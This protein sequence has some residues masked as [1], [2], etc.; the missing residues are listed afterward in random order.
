MKRLFFISGLLFLILSCTTGGSPV[1][2]KSDKKQESVIKTDT[3]ARS[4]IKD[5]VFYIHRNSD[6]FR[7]KILVPEKIRGNLLILHGWNLPADELCSKT[8]LCKMALDSG[9]VLIIPDFGKTT[10]QWQNYPETLKKYLKY[11]TRH[12]M[13]DTFLM[14]MQKL[15][16]LNGNERNFVYGVSTGGRGA[17][18][19]ALENP[20]IF[21][22]AACLSADFDHSNLGDEPINNGFY[23]SQKLFP[24]RRT[25]KDNIYNRAAEFTNALFLTHGKNDKVCTVTQTSDFSIK[26]AQA[27]PNLK[28]ET[29]LDTKGDH[30]YAW[31]DKKTLPILQFFARF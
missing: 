23:G 27:N 26:L 1:S 16:L 30:T 7:I 8:S 31:W 24:E 6:S 12:W 22:A 14:E 10:Y 15:N 3:V 25:G 4:R 5:T 28:V 19:L 13:Q 18:L 17:A 2:D 20:S 29:E 9:Y 21:K 11:P